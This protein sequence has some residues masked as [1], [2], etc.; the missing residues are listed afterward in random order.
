MKNTI[1]KTSKTSLLA[2]TTLLAVACGSGGDK[3]AE[4]AKLKE[5]KAE[6]ETKIVALEKELGT[7]KTDSTRITTVMTTTVQPQTFKHFVEIQGSLDS[8]NNIN[9]TPKMGGNV[10]QVYVK[11]G[12][13][14]KAG[15]VLLVTDDATLRQNLAQLQTGYE[16]AK[17]TFE[18]QENL[19][20]Q[21]IGS[22]IQYLQAKNQKEGVERQIATLQTQIAMTRVT[23][24]INGTVN[25]VNVKIGEMAAPGAPAVQVV[26]LAEMRVKAKVAD[27]YINSIKVGDPVTVKFPDIDE[28]IQARL[29]FVGQVVNS[30]TR[31]F[32]I[33]ISVPNKDNKFKPNLLAVVNINDKT[34]NNALVIDQN[35]VQNTESGTIIYVAA[36]E[37]GKTVAK[38]KK[39]TQGLSYNGKVEITS[40]LDA[41]SQLITV[42]SQD[43][44][45]GQV[46][47]VNQQ[48]ASK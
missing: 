14:V 7:N 3:K 44:V 47:K 28:E 13:Y 43:L 16:L 26:N 5:Q 30:M 31:T 9:V 25:A 1:I 2:A 4:L 23:S 18:R 19:W 6:L 37:G 46:I 34:K 12:D 42:G 36:N 35:L 8:R 22:E 45:D 33:E 41:G 15:Q 10:T 39:V 20:K 29:T 48:V 32:D 27:A 17:T 38:A 11:E 24:P 40:G 21:Q